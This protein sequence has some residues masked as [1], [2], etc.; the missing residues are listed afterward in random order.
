M[1]RKSDPWYGWFRKVPKEQ[2]DPEFDE[3]W[4]ESCC[5]ISVDENIYRTDCPDMHCKRF[6]CA[7]AFN[8]LP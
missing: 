3:F 1:K 2:R 4:V 7:P 8:L 5:P 6:R